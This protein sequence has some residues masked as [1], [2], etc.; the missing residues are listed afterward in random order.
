DGVPSP[1]AAKTVGAG[2]PTL[3]KCGGFEAASGEKYQEALA[4]IKRGAARLKATPRG[5]VEEGFTPCAK[6]REREARSERRR[7]EERR[8]YDAIRADRKVYDEYS[9][10]P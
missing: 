2:T 5:D 3:P 9:G 6:D 10:F 1:S 8:V 4:I 7:A